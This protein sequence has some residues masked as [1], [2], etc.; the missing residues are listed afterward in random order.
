MR[1]PVISLLCLCLPLQ[2]C[3]SYH[4]AANDDAVSD[5]GGEPA[6]LRRYDLN[7]DGSISLQE[8]D[9][10]L[11]ADF[12]LVDINHDGR[13]QYSEYSRENDRRLAQSAEDATPLTDWNGDGVVDFTEFSS[14]A[15]SLFQQMDR[16]GDNVISPSEMRARPTSSGP[17]SQGSS[18]G[19]GRS[20]GGRRGQ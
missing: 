14:V 9:T 20:G 3:A 19:R 12:D 13:L 11:H 5:Q 16:N 15:H 8:F 2:A 1:H 4:P 17:P 6:A 10:V 7:K 18:K